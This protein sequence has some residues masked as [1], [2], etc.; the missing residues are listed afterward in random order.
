MISV[1]LFLYKN[2]IRLGLN[3]PWGRKL[4][5]MVLYGVLLLELK[6]NNMVLIL[7]VFWVGKNEFLTKN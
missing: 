3:E 5:F 6:H 1:N 4:F 2:Q 7:Y